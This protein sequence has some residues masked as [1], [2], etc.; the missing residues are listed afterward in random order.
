M[1]RRETEFDHE[2]VTETKKKL[3]NLPLQSFAAQ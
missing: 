1:S 2:L 3:K